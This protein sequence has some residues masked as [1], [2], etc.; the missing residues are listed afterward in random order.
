MAVNGRVSTGSLPFSVVPKKKSDH[1]KAA[2][3]RREKDVE[4]LIKGEPAHAN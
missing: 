1:P 4:G 2:R 3:H